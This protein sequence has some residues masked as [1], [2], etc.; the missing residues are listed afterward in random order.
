MNK[1]DEVSFLRRDSW[2]L[3]NAVPSFFD[4]IPAV[5]AVVS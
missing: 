4:G 2:I 1:L 5:T 3:S